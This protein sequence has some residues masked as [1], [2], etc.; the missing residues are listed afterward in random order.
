M[1]QFRLCHTFSK[2]QE[3]SS[4]FHTITMFLSLRATRNPRSGSMV[5]LLMEG[6]STWPWPLLRGAGHS[7]TCQ[8]NQQTLSFSQRNIC[9][10]AAMKQTIQEVLFSFRFPI[11]YIDFY[12]VYCRFCKY[13]LSLFHSSLFIHFLL[14]VVRTIGTSVG[15]M[16]FPAW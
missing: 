8:D 13:I 12:C 4:F 14:A 11:V 7:N 10:K 9:F 2:D 3:D 5:T 16:G 15:W 6:P 1:I